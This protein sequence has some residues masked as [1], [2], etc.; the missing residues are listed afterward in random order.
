LKIT[1]VNICQVCWSWCCLQY[2]G[3]YSL[4]DFASISGNR[5]MPFWGRR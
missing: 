4:V 5:A 2:I 3:V 1:D